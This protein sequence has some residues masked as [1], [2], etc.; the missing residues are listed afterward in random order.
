MEVNK[1][2]NGFYRIQ[3]WLQLQVRKY[4]GHGEWKMCSIRSN[5]ETNML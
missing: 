5:K 4:G 1:G 2:Y 3:V